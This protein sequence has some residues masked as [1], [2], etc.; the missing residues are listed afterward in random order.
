MKNNS[1]FSDAWCNLVFDGR[2]KSYGA[3]RLRKE[4]EKTTLSALIITV[5]F[6]VTCLSFPFFLSM[7][8]TAS[9]PMARLTDPT[10]FILRTL[11]VNPEVLVAPKPA[12]MKPKPQKNSFPVISSDKP[13]QPDEPEMNDLEEGITDMLID[14]ATGDVSL[15]QRGSLAAVLPV[16]TMIYSTL[17]VDVKPEFPGGENALIDFYRKNVKYPGSAIKKNKT[18]T[19]YISFIIDRNGAVTEIVVLRGVMGERSLEE[20]AVRVTGLLPQWTPGKQ[21]GQAVQVMVTIPVNFQL[22]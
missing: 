13:E 15:D 7:F 11:P 9:G 8:K 22:R 4:S 2:N 5:C 21:H 3:F 19:V 14:T 1:I 18:G 20:E 17:S 12:A 6:S 10:I 16:D